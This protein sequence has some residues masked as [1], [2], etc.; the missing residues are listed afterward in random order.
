M[1]RTGHE[2]ERE[3]TPTKFLSENPDNL[4][5]MRVDRNCIQMNVN[6]QGVKC[7]LLLIGSGHVPIMD[8]CEQRNE[9]SSSTKGGNDSLSAVRL[10]SKK[11]M[12]WSGLR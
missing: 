6:K 12:K 7:K 1:V 4:R 10:R 8:F 9:P 3:E 5:A 2:R 11:L